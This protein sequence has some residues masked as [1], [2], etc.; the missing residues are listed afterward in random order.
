VV[1]IKFFPE[2]LD[3]FFGNGSCCRLSWGKV[4]ATSAYTTPL[5]LSNGNATAKQLTLTSEPRKSGWKKSVAEID[6]LVT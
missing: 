5:D 6:V 3:F 1:V 4:P 2:A